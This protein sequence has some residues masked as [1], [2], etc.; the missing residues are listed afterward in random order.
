MRFVKYTSLIHPHTESGKF[1]I[2]D[3][4]GDTLTI[5]EG[6]RETS[7]Q[8]TKSYASF[9]KCMEEA[10][11]LVEKKLKAGYREGHVPDNN[12]GSRDM[13]AMDYQD[14]IKKSRKEKRR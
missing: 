2:L 4:K 5:T 9:E 1:W 14:S 11:R 10:Q 13:E 8:S 3:A 6:V 12:P 7:K